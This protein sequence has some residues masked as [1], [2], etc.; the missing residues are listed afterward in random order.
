[1]RHSILVAFLLAGVGTAAAGP[2]DAK[3]VAARQKRWSVLTTKLT[4]ESWH[5]LR[6]SPHSGALVTPAPDG[7]THA[8]AYRA[9]VEHAVL[10]DQ[11]VALT[12]KGYFRQTPAFSLMIADAQGQP[13]AEVHHAV[14]GKRKGQFRLATLEGTTAHASEEAALK[15]F[16]ESKPGFTKAVEDAAQHSTQVVANVKRN[17]ERNWDLHPQGM[18]RPE[19]PGSTQLV[20]QR[21]M[22]GSVPI[23]RIAPGAEE[24]HLADGEVLG[25][26]G[27]VHEAD[28]YDR[29]APREMSMVGRAPASS[30]GSIP[31]LT[32]L[33]V[34]SG[35]KVGERYRV[36]LTEPSG[37]PR[38]FEVVIDQRESAKQ[39]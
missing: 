25:L 3:G 23:L 33:S 15:A 24:I 38:T 19:H 29:F 17:F 5:Q 6:I 26:E 8:Q 16:F 37:Q 12:W 21:G 34:P 9:A 14:A 18:I 20:Y 28:I 36:E 32:L 2:L 39:P 10:K 4:A 1:M 11:P 31:A 35:S 13:V 7:T 27:T 22:F 30:S